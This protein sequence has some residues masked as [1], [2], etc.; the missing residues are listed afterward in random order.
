MNHV[1][2]HKTAQNSSFGDGKNRFTAGKQ[3]PLLHQ[4]FI[5]GSSNCSPGGDD[6]LIESF[7][8]TL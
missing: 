6:I 8:G 1:I 3:R 4:H 5:A 2:H 7:R